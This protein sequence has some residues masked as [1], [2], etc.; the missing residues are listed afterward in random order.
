MGQVCM[1]RVALLVDASVGDPTRRRGL[2]HHL[3][4]SACWA[5]S[6]QL[7]FRLILVAQVL[8]GSS[9]YKFKADMLEVCVQREGGGGAV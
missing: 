1:R 4:V 2:C 7:A 5:V 6:L 3:P 9:Y 8:V